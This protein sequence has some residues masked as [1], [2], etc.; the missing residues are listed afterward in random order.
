ML[1]E[2]D[3][4]D[5]RGYSPL[6]KIIKL[7]WIKNV[8]TSLLNIGRYYRTLK[9]SCILTCIKLPVKFCFWVSA[10]WGQALPSFP[11]ARQWAWEGIFNQGLC[12]LEVRQLPALP[13]WPGSWSGVGFCIYLC[14]WQLNLLIHR[15]QCDIWAK[16]P[17]LLSKEKGVGWRIISR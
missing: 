17:H 15:G 9:L 4:W 8:S 11:S 3:C 14:V 16:G 1:K 2:G 13:L 6:C 5:Q 7:D 12:P 10:S